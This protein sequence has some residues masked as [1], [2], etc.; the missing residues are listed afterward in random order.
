MERADFPSRPINSQADTGLR[1][2]AG[3]VEPL[4]QHLK[5]EKRLENFLDDFLSVQ[6][7]QAGPIFGLAEADLLHEDVPLRHKCSSEKRFVLRV[8]IITLGSRYATIERKSP[9]NSA[10]HHQSNAPCHEG[11]QSSHGL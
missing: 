5:H 3:A 2:Y 8:L 6:R 4:V 9:S 7:E 10:N 1:W 11:S